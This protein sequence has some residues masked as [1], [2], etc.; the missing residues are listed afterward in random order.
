MAKRLADL[1]PG[2]RV[3]LA[4][5]MGVVARVVT[6][7]PRRMKVFTANGMPDGDKPSCEIVLDILDGARRGERSSVHGDPE[8]R[9][10]LG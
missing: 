2:D 5:P 7:T 3:K 1:V 6:N 8:S 10:A 4:E 9:V